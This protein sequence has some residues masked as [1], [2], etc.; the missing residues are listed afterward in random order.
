MVR[1]GCYITRE[2]DQALKREAK[3]LGISEAEL[4]RRAID[5]WL[6]SRARL[7]ERRQEAL[8]QLL[9]HTRHLAMHHRWPG[10]SSFDR[11]ALYT[12]RGAT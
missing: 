6:G 12:D 4:I 2:Q 3:L 7:G 1:K 11:E 5:S 9:Q 8:A 10:G